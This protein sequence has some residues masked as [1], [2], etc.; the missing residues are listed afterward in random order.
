DNN[1]LWETKLVRRLADLVRQRGFRL[2]VPAL[3]HAERVAQVRRSHGASFDIAVVQAFIDTHNIEVVG[4]DR[5][6]AERF[7][8]EVCTTYPDADGWHAAKRTKCATRFRVNADAGQV[9]PATV[10]WFIAYGHG[11]AADARERVVL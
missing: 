7:V 4:F 9:C 5:G 11:R 6:C 8:Q 1:A 3:V 2:Q 10:D